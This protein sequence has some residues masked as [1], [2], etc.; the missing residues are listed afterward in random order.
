MTETMKIED[1]LARGGRLTSPANVPARYRAELMKIMAIFV[2]SELAGAA[3]FADRIN[4]AA[5][6]EGRIAAARI[7]AE[8]TAHAGKVLKLMGEFGAATDRYVSHHP[9]TARLDRG[10]EVGSTRIDHDMRL[11]VFNYPLTGWADAVVMNWLMGMAVDIQL[12]ELGQL[13]Y[14]PLAETFREIRPTEAR[15]TELAAAGIALLLSEGGEVQASVDYWW[16]RVATSFGRESSDK[17]AMLQGFGLRHSS[18]ADLRAAWELRAGAA[19]KAQ[20]LEV[21]A[22]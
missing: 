14:Q 16:P 11:S 10:A 19:L 2:D 20:A 5:G 1:Y 4:D 22:G 17:L 12:G 6:I 15:H 7:V 9:W 3:G 21:P 18:N 13:S 8:K